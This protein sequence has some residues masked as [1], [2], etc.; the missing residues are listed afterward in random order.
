MFNEKER[1]QNEVIFLCR[2]NKKNC[3]RCTI[4]I[5]TLVNRKKKGNKLFSLIKQNSNK[6]EI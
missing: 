4:S 2:M 6:Y 3:N 5:E 1:K